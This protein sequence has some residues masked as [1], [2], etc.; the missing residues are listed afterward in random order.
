[1]KRQYGKIDPRS[2]LEVF[3]LNFSTLK[4]FFI[5]KILTTESVNFVL[6]FLHA[7]LGHLTSQV[8]TK[9][10]KKQRQKVEQKSKQLEA[11]SKGLCH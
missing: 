10:V 7:L 3:G 5:L 2:I 4:F 6:Y 9:P 11:S 8:P 1:M